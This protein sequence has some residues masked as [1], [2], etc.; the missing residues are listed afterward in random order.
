MEYHKEAAKLTP[1]P[2]EE[3]EK[4]HKRYLEEREQ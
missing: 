1:F 2:I 4:W 3:V